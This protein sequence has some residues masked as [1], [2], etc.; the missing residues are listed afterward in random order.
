MVEMDGKYYFMFGDTFSTGTTNWRSNVLGYT[1]EKTPSEGIQLTWITDTEGNAKEVIPSLKAYDFNEFTSIPTNGISHEGIL[2]YSYMNVAHWGLTAHWD[3][4]Y[5]EWC[6]SVDQGHT[7]TKT[8]IGWGPESNF[9]Q[10]ACVKDDTTLYVYGI[11]SSRFGG[12]KLAK[13]PIAQ[14]LEMGAYRYYAGTDA[15]GE[16]IWSIYEKEAE[17]IVPGPIG[18][19]SVMYNPYLGKWIMTYLNEHTLDLEIREGDSPWSWSRIPLILVDH[20]VAGSDKL[21]YAPFMTPDYMENAGEIIYFTMSQWMPIY[22]VA[23]MK[24]RLVRQ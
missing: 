13:V 20:T 18:E 15:N 11:P 21:I 17:L 24:A 4:G 2:Y 9:I 19:F 14:L 7:W 16:P 10:L 1:E 6:T 8:S 23:W 3:C 12:V 22:N 5:S